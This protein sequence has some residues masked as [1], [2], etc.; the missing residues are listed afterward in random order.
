MMQLAF[1]TK[2][3][4]NLGTCE[5]KS[6]SPKKRRYK[7]SRA[8][9]ERPRKD[10]NHEPRPMNPFMVWQKEY[11][12][13]VQA[14]CPHL[15]NHMVSITLGQ[16]W[17][18]IP[19][20]EREGYKR[21]SVHLGSKH[22]QE[23]PGYKYKPKSKKTIASTVKVPSISTPKFNTASGSKK[24][25]SRQPKDTETRLKK[26]QQLGEKHFVDAYTNSVKNIQ[27]KCYHSTTLLQKEIQRR[28]PIPAETRFKKTQAY[29]S[30]NS[31]SEPC[32]SS[33]GS[34]VEFTSS[35]RKGVSL[36]STITGAGQ[37]SPPSPVVSDPEASEQHITATVNSCGGLEEIMG[38]SIFSAEDFTS[39]STI[40]SPQYSWEQNQLDYPMPNA[41]STWSGRDQNNDTKEGFNG[42]DPWNDIQQLLTSTK[43][44][45]M[46]T[47][48]YT[49]DY[50][51]K[52][53]RL[54]DSLPFVT[55]FDPYG[56]HSVPNSMFNVH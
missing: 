28:R 1:S 22:K 14:R 36:D 4:S 31:I 45:D 49:T 16:L 55:D 23:F 42:Y 27:D 52:P 46:W 32:S 15:Q 3:N 39:Q 41:P 26:Q 56:L 29:R 37:Y 11:R 50:I 54:H 13:I 38:F 25:T 43:N 33:C 35:D 24:H 7:P 40:K 18:R 21:K 51:G 12:P 48:A 19:V 34:D 47:S 8:G 6:S 10:S 2:V 44:D 17:K 30:N 20:A 9:K 5:I 53:I